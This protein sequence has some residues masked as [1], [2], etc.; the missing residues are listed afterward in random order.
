MVWKKLISISLME[1]FP[2][3]RVYIWLLHGRLA[4]GINRTDEI[5][6]GLWGRAK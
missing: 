2:R 3:A 4:E 6:T 1:E 5:E